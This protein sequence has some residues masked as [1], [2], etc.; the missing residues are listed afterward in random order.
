VDEKTVAGVVTL[1]AQD[2]EIVEF[3]AQGM[4]DTESDRPM[5]KDTILQIMS[6][7][8]P[9]TPIGNDGGLGKNA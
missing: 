5:R 6:I 2:N 1:V 3:D 9:V 8:K 4:A 7:T